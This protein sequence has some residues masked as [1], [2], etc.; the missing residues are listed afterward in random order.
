MADDDALPSVSVVVP[1]YNENARIAG[2]VASLLAQDYPRELLRIIVV[3]NGSTDGTFATIQSIAGI[4]A[5]QE[6]TPG[7]Y[8]ARNLGLRHVES[9]VVCFTDADCTAASDWVRSAVRHLASDAVGVVAGRVQLDS[10]GGRRATA[11]ELFEKAFAFRQ[12]QNVRA[13]GC[14]TANWCSRSQ[15]LRELGGF[16]ATLRSGGDRDLSERIAKAGHRIVYAP[17][18]VVHHPARASYSELLRKRRRLAG[19][20]YVRSYLTGKKSFPRLLR[21]FANKALRRSR[22]LAAQD[23]IDAVDRVRVTA[24][25][26]ALSLASMLEA[27]R[28]RC[29]GEPLR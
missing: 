10:S 14:V 13:N 8:A 9:D 12:E 23:G 25:I 27:V 2:C 22:E 11:S 6:R 3:D 15:L 1:A 24:V 5:L 16:D 7:S 26:L 18:A 4:V 17:D 29:G 28:L 20:L 19:G 21:G